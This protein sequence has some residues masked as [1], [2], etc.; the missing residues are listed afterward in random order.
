[1]TNSGSCLIARKFPF[2]K[3]TN[4]CDAVSNK[5]NCSEVIIKIFTRCLRKRL[6][7]KGQPERL[8]IERKPTYLS[9]HTFVVAVLVPFRPIASCKL[10]L[11]AA[12]SDVGYNILLGIVR[13]IP[14]IIYRSQHR[15]TA[16]SPVG[17]HFIP[18]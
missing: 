1:M 10:A 15:E 4:S 8:L 5:L 7:S 12:I 3:T 11:L 18:I 6:P 17:P 14:G 9:N 13:C 16:S 2:C